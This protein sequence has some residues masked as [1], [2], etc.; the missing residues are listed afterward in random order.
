MLIEFLTSRFSYI[1]D[2]TL[3]IIA[4][5]ALIKFANWSVNVFWSKDVWPKLQE[6]ADAMAHYFGLRLI[7]IALVVGLTAIAGAIQ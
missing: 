4:F 1:L 3:W 6:N 5:L 2:C 7:A